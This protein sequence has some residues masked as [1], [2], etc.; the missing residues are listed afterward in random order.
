M[1]LEVFSKLYKISLAG[2]LSIL[3]FFPVVLFGQDESDPLLKEWNKARKSPSFKKDTLLILRLNDHSK[4]YLY[5]Q[6]DSAIFYAQKALVLAEEHNY[7]NGKAWCLNSLGTGW[8]V[9]GSYDLAL[10]AYLESKD[11]FQKLGNDGR[12]AWAL[13]NIGLIYIAQARYDQAIQQ[14]KS[15]VGN[16]VAEEDSSF[17]ATVLYNLGLSYNYKGDYDQALN[18]LEKALEV[19]EQHDLYRMKAISLNRMGE[20]Y[21]HKKEFS[22]ASNYYNQVINDS[23]YQSNWEMSFAH[24]GLAQTFYTKGNNTKAIYH[25]TLGL[26]LAKKVKAKWDV[27][28]VLKILASA[29]AAE[30]N[31]KNAYEYHNLYKLYYDSLFSEAKEKEINYLNLK[32][33]EAENLQL[34]KQNQI[35][36]Q[37]IRIN[38]MFNFGIALLALFFLTFAFIFYR[39]SKLKSKLN[40]FLARRN[41]DI[42]RRNKLISRQKEALEILNSTKDKLFSI[43]SHDL[44]SP[45]SSIT[46]TLDIIR[47]GALTEY[48]Q[49]K[50]FKILH[51]K[52]MLVTQMLNNLLQWANTQQIGITVKSGKYDLSKITAQVVPVARF[53]AGEK[54]IVIKHHIN[55]DLFVYVDEDHVRIILQNLLANAIKFTPDGGTVNI[56]YSEVQE[57]Q[58]IHIKD[59]GVGMSAEKLKKLFDLIGSDI[60]VI[61]TNNEEG[62]GIGLML[63]QQ[64]VKENNG[65]IEIDSKEGEGTE[66]KVSFP[67][68][69]DLKDEKKLTSPLEIEN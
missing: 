37:R 31:F 44:R 46:G 69:F 18:F 14:Y 36:Q 67:K 42:D 34:A 50:I 63:V 10:K 61:G 32:Q 53:L 51:H 59:S 38:R 52:V 1:R 66:V 64:F 12:V 30:E 6:T 65:K 19:C 11:L 13:N 41:V 45:L 62:T 16:K 23:A 21:F 4:E 2:I 9:N 5:D 40:L 58:I 17:F 29:Y 60:S 28:R 15:L 39:N 26:E 22:K 27:A 56:F 68:Y 3:V 48:E 57:Y 20:V 7:L 8:Y 43:I 24:A 54:N 25:G 33:E 47:R 49:Q 35:N 55:N